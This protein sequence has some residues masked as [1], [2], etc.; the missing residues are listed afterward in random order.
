MEKFPIVY[1]RFFYIPD[2]S[3]NGYLKVYDDYIVIEYI[4]MSIMNWTTDIKIEKSQIEKVYFATSCE[5][6]KFFRMINCIFRAGKRYGK[7]VII[8]T[9]NK[10]YKI[11]ILFDNEADADFIVKSI[12]K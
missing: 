8:A 5:V 7:K 11:T 10:D 3:F 2:N 1:K 4:G 12:K 6:P 9:E